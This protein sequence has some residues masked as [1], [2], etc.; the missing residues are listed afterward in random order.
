MRGVYTR[1][2]K[3]IH[4]RK[5][6][7]F[8]L[9]DIIDF[10]SSDNDFSAQFEGLHAYKPSIFNAFALFNLTIHVFSV[11]ITSGKSTISEENEELN[12]TCKFFN[13]KGNNY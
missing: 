6:T 2:T 10:E 5:W 8:N 1:Y 12:N 13:P 7:G 11:S 3:K 4:R 9:G